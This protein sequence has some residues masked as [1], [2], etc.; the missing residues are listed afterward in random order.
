MGQHQGDRRVVG[1]V[2]DGVDQRAVTGA[3]GGDAAQDGTC[4]HAATS[5][6]LACA[7]AG[8]PT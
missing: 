8:T 1:T 7:A 5:G 2:D 4:A 3:D 6:V